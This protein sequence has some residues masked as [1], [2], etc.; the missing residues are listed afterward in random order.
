MIFAKTLNLCFLELCA[1]TTSHFPQES[2]RG[3]KNIYIHPRAGANLD[4][5]FQLE[6][7]KCISTLCVGSE[8]EALWFLYA[9]PLAHPAPVIIVY[10]QRQMQ[11]EGEHISAP[12][13][14][15]TVTHK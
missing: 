14:S 9:C 10:S 2:K 1:S 8:G 3:E 11:G 12:K 7:T 6:Y 4:F 5:S 13:V 15:H